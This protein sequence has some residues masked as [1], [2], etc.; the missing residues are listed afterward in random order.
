MELNLP[1]MS[2]TCCVT[3]DPF[4]EDERVTSLLVRPDGGEAV[5]RYD[6]RAGVAAEFSPVGRVAC[7][8]T[9]LYSP[10]RHE[11][12][13]ERSM[14]L[15]AENIFLTLADPANELSEADTRL[16]QFL[17][18]MLERKRVLRPK[19]RNEAGTHHVVEH[20]GSKQR[21]EVVAGEL[22]PEFFL[23]VQEQLSVLVGEPAGSS[24]PVPAGPPA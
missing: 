8:W 9:Q 16:V 3:G 17:A 23:A 4:T 24:A 2:E 13:P 6:L 22:S 11:E 20:A 12:N 1:P 5:V 14:K 7:R 21:F 19:G 18:L 10:R 15:T